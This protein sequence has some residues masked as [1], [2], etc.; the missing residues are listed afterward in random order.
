MNRPALRKTAND[1]ETAR[2]PLSHHLGTGRRSDP[3]GYVY[4][5]ADFAGDFDPR[6]LP[7]SY[8][9]ARRMTSEVPLEYAHIGPEV[10]IP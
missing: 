10:R 3:P 2:V 1:T 7:A 6:F 5:Y 9:I 8:R 4:A